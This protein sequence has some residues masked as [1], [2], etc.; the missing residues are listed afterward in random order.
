[1]MMTVMAVKKN[2]A[3]GLREKF[4]LPELS[5]DEWEKVFRAVTV[6]ECI[7]RGHK[8]ERICC[9][10]FG[11]LLGRGE[12]YP[13]EEL[14]DELAKRHTR[15]SARMALCEL[16]KRGLIEGGGKGG[17]IWFTKGVANFIGVPYFNTYEFKKR[18]YAEGKGPSYSKKKSTTNEEEKNTEKER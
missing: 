8:Y 18:M 11:M 12:P 4:R 14:Y 2:I 7:E 5:D 3:K 16:R 1:M 9:E 15:G 10:V 6:L 13:V 17:Y